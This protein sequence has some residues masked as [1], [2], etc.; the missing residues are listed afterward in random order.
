MIRRRC[1]DRIKFGVGARGLPRTALEIHMMIVVVVAA[2]HIIVVSSAIVVREGAVKDPN[3]SY[4]LILLYRN[5]QS[6]SIFILYLLPYSQSFSKGLLSSLL[7]DFKI[8]SNYFSSS[9]SY[10]SIMV[11]GLLGGVMMRGY[12]SFL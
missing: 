3:H 1:R 12:S 9:S 7:L 6:L 11:L 10:I 8:S 4:S 2:F 5:N